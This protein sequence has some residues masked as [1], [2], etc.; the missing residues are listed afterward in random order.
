ML[1]RNIILD[2]VM[3]ISDLLH[4]HMRFHVTVE[5][6]SFLFL[7]ECYVHRDMDVQLKIAGI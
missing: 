6:L 7:F 5:L 1:V 3:E 2:I 4:L